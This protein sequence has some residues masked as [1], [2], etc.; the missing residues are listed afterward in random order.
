M[1]EPAPAPPER[2][3]YRPLLRLLAEAAEIV[4]AVGLHAFFQW[5]AHVTHQE[6]EW[7]A[8]FL[9]GAAALF[10]A[11]SFGVIGGAEV[12]A[13]CWAAVRFAWRKIREE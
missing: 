9:I 1:R 2:A 7:L 5:W 8:R 11:L 4:F 10:A 3:W 6:H 13:N 12:V